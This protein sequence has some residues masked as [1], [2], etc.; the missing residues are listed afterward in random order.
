MEIT[1]SYG[2][3]MIFMGSWYPW[4]PVLILYDLIRTVSPS[5]TIQ[6]YSTYAHWTYLNMTAA[7]DVPCFSGHVRVD[8]CETRWHPSLCA[9]H[10]AGCRTNAP[11]ATWRPWVTCVIQKH[12]HR[13]LRKR[14]HRNP[15]VIRWINSRTRVERHSVSLSF[16]ELK[17]STWN[18]V[19]PY[20]GFCSTTELFPQKP[21]FKS[22]ISRLTH[23]Q[24]VVC[25]W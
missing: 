13:S 21:S 6:P 9:A 25:L 14:T 10:A 7:A 3:L 8:R 22:R 11:L 17:K 12:W 23:P 24:G 20:R 1:T 16:F 18:S 4:Y 5:D 2:Y 19:D 15:E